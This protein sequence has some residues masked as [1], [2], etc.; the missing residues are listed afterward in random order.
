MK[1]LEM[2]SSNTKTPQMIS[3][4]MKALEII[5]YCLW[6]KTTVS[7]WII[8]KLQILMMHCDEYVMIWDS[9]ESWCKYCIQCSVNSTACVKSAVRYIRKG[10]SEINSTEVSPRYNPYKH[11][12][13]ED[14]SK[15]NV[16]V[17]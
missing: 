14:N 9:G 11:T 3:S 13:V 2:I 6:S 16:T 17:K 15:N 4:N 7:G 10:P 5:S 1:T 12:W 8:Y